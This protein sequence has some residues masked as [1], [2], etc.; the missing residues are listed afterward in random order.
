MIGSYICMIHE[1]TRQVLF[2]S[3][4]APGLKKLFMNQLAMVCFETIN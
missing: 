4:T 3:L 2:R 1:Y